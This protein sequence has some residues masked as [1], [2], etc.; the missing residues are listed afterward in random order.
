M[1]GVNSNC[2]GANINPHF[3]LSS[4]YWE[5]FVIL[6]SLF[7]LLSI[8]LLLMKLTLQFFFYKNIFDKNK[9]LL[10]LY[11]METY[12]YYECEISFC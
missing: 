8:S 3:V 4:S 5:G 1:I 6:I 2:G 10:L 7:F 12:L 11:S 9:F